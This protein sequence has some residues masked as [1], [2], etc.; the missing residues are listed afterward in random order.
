MLPFLD[1]P[2]FF[3]Q[4]HFLSFAATLCNRL[5]EALLKTHLLNSCDQ[6]WGCS[7]RNVFARWFLHWAN[8]KQLVASIWSHFPGSPLI[9]Q[10]CIHSFLQK[11]E[12][13]V[14]EQI[15]PLLTR[16]GKKKTAP[17]PMSGIK[18]SIKVDDCNDRQMKYL[19][20]ASG[21]D[22]KSQKGLYSGI[23]HNHGS[24]FFPLTCISCFDDSSSIGVSTRLV[25]F[26]VIQS[27][28]PI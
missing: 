25:R 15:H 1:T 9:A 6:F 24:Q 10:T 13:E 18:L 12:I 5:H 3:P 17:N 4:V 2:I 11:C 16:L 22:L 23:T 27:A 8:A 7:F 20:P 14:K 28:E 19:I 26:R 21:T